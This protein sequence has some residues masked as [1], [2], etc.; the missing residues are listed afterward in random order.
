M[1]KNGLEQLGVLPVTLESWR[2]VEE[3]DKVE[4]VGVNNNVNCYK[5]NQQDGALFVGEVTEENER[6]SYKGET[7]ELL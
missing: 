5:I 4:M 7:I 3:D 6:E 2:P 1:A